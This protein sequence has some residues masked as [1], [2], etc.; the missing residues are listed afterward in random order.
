MHWNAGRK[1]NCL[2]FKKSFLRFTHPSWVY[3][4]GCPPI[5][6]SLSTN[7]LRH[8]TP[9][10]H[11]THD[12]ILEIR[13]QLKCQ[14]ESK[15]MF[16]KKATKIWQNL[17]VFYLSVRYNVS[18][19]TCYTF[20]KGSIMFGQKIGADISG[21]LERFPQENIESK[22]NIGYIY[23]KDL[24]NSKTLRIPERYLALLIITDKLSSPD[25]WF[26]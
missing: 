16:S 23:R 7:Y 17:P 8:C 9:A 13:H 26:M 6:L 1:P 19:L 10:N 21:C 14:G 11:K 22:R 2:D 4:Y 12:N 18:F 25:K 5:V 20:F 24:D 15:F 3:V